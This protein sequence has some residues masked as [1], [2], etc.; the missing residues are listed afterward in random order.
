[1][2][3]QLPLRENRPEIYDGG[4]QR[5]Y[6][7]EGRKAAPEGE[8]NPEEGHQQQNPGRRM[9]PSREKCPQRQNDQSVDD[10]EESLEVEID[11]GSPGPHS[12]EERKGPR[13]ERHDHRH[14]DPTLRCFLPVRP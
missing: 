6:D 9:P 4:R 11:T 3:R 13:Q 5:R 8:R 7:R 2:T 10:T 14:I 12:N 1:M